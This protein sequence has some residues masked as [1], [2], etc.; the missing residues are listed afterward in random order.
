MKLGA[1]DAAASAVTDGFLG[2][3]G[4]TSRWVWVSIAFTLAGFGLWSHVVRVAALS[5][6]FPLVNVVHI[7]IPL[8]SWVFLGEQIGPRRWLGI[9]LVVA[10]LVTIARPQ[11]ELEGRKR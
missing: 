4:L 8:S 9:G 5:V 2:R 11:A 1:G 6:A 10:G 7:L 3:I